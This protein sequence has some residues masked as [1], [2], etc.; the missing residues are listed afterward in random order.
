MPWLAPGTHVWQLVVS[1]AHSPV[2]V[3]KLL[4]SPEADSDLGVVAGM[5]AVVVTIV[6][7]VM[8]VVVE[9]GAR[10]AVLSVGVKDRR[11]EYARGASRRKHRTT[12]GTPSTVPSPEACVTLPF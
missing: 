2:L 11:V 9:T 12:S 3:L 4:L 7:R 8:I 1:A 5:V 6:V 10:A